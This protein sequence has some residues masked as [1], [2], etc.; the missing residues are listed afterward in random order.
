MPNIKSAKKKLR[1][2]KKR[3]ERNEFSEHTIKKTMKMIAKVTG[4][5]SD[6]EVKKAFSIIDK[7][8]KKNIIH[9]N[10]ASRLKS[11]VTRL[12]SSAK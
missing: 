7:A 2:D 5:K 9:K 12:T 8:A 10:K 4:K 6:D 1:Q 11:R 3:E